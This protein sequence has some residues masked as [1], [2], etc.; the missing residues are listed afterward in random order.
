M[1]ISQAHVAELKRFVLQSGPV[2][3][4]SLFFFGSVAPELDLLPVDSA[5]DIRRL[6][7]M[8]GTVASCV[9]LFTFARALL[10]VRAEADPKKVRLGYVLFWFCGSL[11]FDAVWEIPLWTTPFIKNTRFDAPDA[12]RHLPWAVVWWSYGTSDSLYMDVTPFM[13]TFEIW[14]LLG[15]IPALFGLLK[16]ARGE[17]TQRSLAL[18]M[19]SGFAQAYNASVYMFYEAYVDRCAHVHPSRLGWFVYVSLNG[20]WCVASLVACRFSYQLLFPDDGHTH[21]D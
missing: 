9:L 11:F 13:V 21:H 7:Q 2:F 14:W 12:A 8:S 6:T 4:L 10:G 18:F 16:Y 3:I 19:V 5:E 17:P 20:F 15:N 1:R